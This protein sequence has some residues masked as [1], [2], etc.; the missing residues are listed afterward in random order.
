MSEIQ[1]RP[2]GLDELSWTDVAAHLAR[3]PRLIIPIGAL[4]QHGPHLPL[5]SNV[6]IA[7]HISYD[8]SQHFGVLRAPT[9]Y[10]GVNVGSER[11]YAGTASLSQKTLHRALNELLAAWELH[12]IREFILITAH[13]H[14][15]H[16]DALATLTTH[17]ARVRVVSVWDVDIADLLLE[18]PGPL[19]AGEAETSVMLYL[20]PKLVRMDRARDFELAPE[21]FARYI[22][23]QL[24]TPPTGGAGVVGHP[25]LANA[26]K[27][28]AIYARILSAIRNAVFLARDP[29]SD[30][31]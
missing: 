9:M 22:R 15:P 16:L 25:T 29:E 5:G 14:E 3:D 23:G 31:L 6:L 12:G 8:L 21:A 28:S 10:Y 26:E 11:A 2:L 1:K 7:R 20:Y 24:P 18:Q 19:H 13:R 4:E 30:T 17:E 27:G